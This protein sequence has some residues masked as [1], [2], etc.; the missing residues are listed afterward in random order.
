VVRSVG[1][2]WGART[3]RV[4]ADDAERALLW[5][6]RKSAFGAVARIKPNYYLHDTVVPRTKLVEVLR[7]IYAIAERHDLL[8]MNVFHAGDGN[9]HPLLVF[10]A[11]EPGA[12]DRVHAAGDEIVAASLAAGGV[13]TGE[14]GVGLEKKAF[15]PDLFS[16]DDLDAQVRLRLAFDPDDL[17]NPDKVLPSPA[18]C[19]DL[20]SVPEGVW[21]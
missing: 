15:M 21:V 9:L 20:Q 16:A 1:E 6:G 2:Q 4:A 19:G 8:V 7:E 12:I 17:M 14:H 11:R 13:L 3:V 5:K 10:D 18:G